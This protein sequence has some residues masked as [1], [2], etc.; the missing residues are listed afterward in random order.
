MRF[1]RGGLWRIGGHECFERGDES[2][3]ILSRRHPN[4]VEIDPTVIVNN[5]IPHTHDLR[6][7]DLRMCDT[8]YLANP[9]CG[10]ANDLKKVRNRELQVVVR[11]EVEP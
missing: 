9:S 3:N 1:M 8:R 2:R 4:D 6:P 11:I 7:I 10:F 5:S